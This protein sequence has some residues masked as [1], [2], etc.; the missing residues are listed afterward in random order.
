ME[1]ILIE[2]IAKLGQIG[3]I[4]RVRD[5]FA[6]NFLLPQGKALRATK[7]N[8]E[9]F[10]G[11]KSELEAKNVT[12]KSSASEAG[13]KLDGQSFVLVRQAGETGQLYGSV[14]A[15]DIADIVAKDGHK[16]ERQQIVLNVPIKII[17]LHT[18]ALALHPEVE[19]KITVNVARSEDE[20]KRQSQG[21]DLTVA[22]TEQEEAKAEARLKA[23]KVFEK[24]PED[25]EIDKGE[26]T[27]Q[28]ANKAK[29]SKA[30]GSANQADVKSASAKRTRGQKKAEPTSEQVDT[31]SAKKA[32]IEKSSK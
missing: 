30:D 3:D 27:E 6:R 22:R 1:V 13:K 28:P 26:T 9:K 20:A 8:K 21:E 18:V 31:K 19:V 10:E 14:S 4:V 32:K 11:M 15:R 29:K 24:L 25:E 5:G 17:G 16:V 2:R 12:R 23:D 7:Q